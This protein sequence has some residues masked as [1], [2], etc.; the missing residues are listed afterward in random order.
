MG[1]HRID[2]A[3]ISLVGWRAR[4]TVKGVTY[5]RF[6]GDAIWN[7]SRNALHAA[8]GW[9]DDARAQRRYAKKMRK[10]IK[11]GAPR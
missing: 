2:R 4:F 9:I 3:D 6:F 5:G 1:V 8:A 11:W 7:G 10:P